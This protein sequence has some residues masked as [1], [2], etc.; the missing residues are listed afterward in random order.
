MTAMDREGEDKTPGSSYHVSNSAKGCLTFKNPQL[1]LSWSMC[2]HFILDEVAELLKRENK[3]FS[4]HRE[5]YRT[6][7]PLWQK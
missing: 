1:Y 6:S 3:I 7:F 4:S 5:R 2:A